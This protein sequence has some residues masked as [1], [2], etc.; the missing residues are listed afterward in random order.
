MASVGKVRKVFAG[1]NT[2]YGFYSFYDYIINSNALRKIILKGGPGVGKSSFMKSIGLAMKEKGYDIE[3]HYCSSDINSLDGL[4]IPKINIALVDGTSP[5]V[6]DPKYPGAF[7]EIL[8]LGDYWNEDGFKKSKND[9]IQYT[10]KISG[11]FKKAYR[12]LNA[13]KLVR[14]NIEDVYKNSQNFANVNILRNK[15]IDKILLNK[16]ICKA[17]GDERHLFASAITPDGF[18]EYLDTTVGTMKN[19]ISLKGNVGTGRT[20][21]LKNIAKM[22]CE[23]GLFTEYFHSPLDPYKLDHIIIPELDTAISTSTFKNS[24]IYDLNE[25][26][27]TTVIRNF[28][29]DLKS[30]NNEFNNLLKH[31]IA[32][33]KKAK[34]NHDM[35]EKYYIPNMNFNEIEKLRD[36]LLNRIIVYAE[37]YTNS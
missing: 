34:E 25:Y 36:K 26:L 16:P 33:L 20:T 32:Y 35:L 3:M 24:T 9:I 19:I 21:M 7:D 4:V 10:N 1:G 31:A 14:D 6:V 2:A 22:A 8:N 28:E 17:I 27:D 15:I 37:S 30:D 12:Y 13:A 5:H 23:R 29:L 18:V 11:L